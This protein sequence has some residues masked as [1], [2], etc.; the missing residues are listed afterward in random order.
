MSYADLRPD[1]ERPCD[2]DCE[3]SS[4]G[5]SPGGAGLAALCRCPGSVLRSEHS[6][7]E[8]RR[9][10]RAGRPPPDSDASR[11]EPDGQADTRRRRRRASEPERQREPHAMKQTGCATTTT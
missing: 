11:R 4:M 7:A 8:W 6:G 3:F 9:Q 5:A 10:V 1:V 2:C